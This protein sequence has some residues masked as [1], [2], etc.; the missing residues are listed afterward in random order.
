MNKP[1]NP[2]EA[3]ELANYII[4]KCDKL[5]NAINNLT[6]QKILYCIQ[7][8]F[9]QKFDIKAFNDPIEAWQFGPAIS[10]VYYT[11]CGNGVMPI[12]EPMSSQ[13]VNI[14]F[15]DKHKEV[16]DQIILMMYNLEPWDINRI[17]MPINGAWYITYQ[18]G[19][20]DKNIWI[21]NH[22]R[23]IPCKLIKERG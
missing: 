20:N 18:A 8:E 10:E 7:R 11:F 9:L 17:A 21:C 19:K 23:I 22:G 6:L 16:I 1:Y 14:V 5:G 2:Y 13:P 15:K 4:V 12:W 3:L